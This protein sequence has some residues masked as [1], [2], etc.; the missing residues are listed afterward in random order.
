MSL[1]RALSSPAVFLIVLFAIVLAALAQSDG[2]AGRPL[3][4]ASPQPRSS[5]WVSRLDLTDDSALPTARCESFA[6]AGSSGARCAGRSA[7]SVGWRSGDIPRVLAPGSVCAWQRRCQFNFSGSNN[8]SSCGLAYS[9]A[10]ADVNGDGH[11]DLLVANQ[12]AD[13]NT[14]SNGGTV[15]VLL[16]NGDGT[17]Q[18]AV[19]Y[20]SGG[21]YAYSVAVADV[22][23]DGHLDLL[24]VN[25]CAS[26]SSCDNGGTV[27]VLLG[28]GDG[29]FQTAVSYN[30]GGEYAYSIAAADVNGDGYP[31]L[32]VANQC[33]NSSNC[34]NGGASVLLGNG[35][36]TF[37]AAV[38]YNSGGEYAFSVAVADVNGDGHPDLLVANDCAS[39][40]N[41]SN[42]TLS[43][44]LGNGDGT[45]Q[46]A[47][48]YNS[49]DLYAKSVAVADVNGDGYPDLLV[50][51]LCANRSNCTGGAVD[52]LLGN[53]DGTFQTAVSYGSGGRMHIRLRWRM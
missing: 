14:C 40:S 24:V 9:V 37:Q 20:N 11:P 3:S 1:R 15:G 34:L 45:F 21:E 23:G 51:S 4:A 38:T 52:V 25:Q 41:C 49:G 50:A 28:N 44:L 48:S 22:N 27:S 46:A 8:Y 53:G 7:W 42:G 19:I 18:P 12:C 32:L 43:V 47:V 35:D 17:F 6:G 16:G 5:L 26:S 36:G 33:A 13:S 2:G 39:S 30:S 10:V 31:D 29:T